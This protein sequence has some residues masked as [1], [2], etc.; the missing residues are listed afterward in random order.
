[1][2]LQRCLA[3]RNQSSGREDA[4]GLPPRPSPLPPPVSTKKLFT[5]LRALSQP[6]PSIPRSTIAGSLDIIK[7][8]TYGKIHNHRKQTSS[9]TNSCAPEGGGAADPEWDHVLK[10]QSPHLF[11]GHMGRWR[12]WMRGFSDTRRSTWN[13]GYGRCRIRS[14]KATHDTYMG[15]TDS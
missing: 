2:G 13:W 14:K 12:T 5:H 4:Y 6:T 10:Y 8:F 11:S 1:M 9:L 15:A 3:G 7:E